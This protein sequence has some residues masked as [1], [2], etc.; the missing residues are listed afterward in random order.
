M[1]KGQITTYESWAIKNAK[2]GY[3]FYSEKQDKDITSIASAHKRKVLTERVIVISS[4]NK[5]PEAKMI[6]K[7]TIL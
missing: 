5:Q 4:K 3:V 7:I 6:T 1:K 2:S